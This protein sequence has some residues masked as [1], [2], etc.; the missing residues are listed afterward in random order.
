MVM[1]KKVARIGGLAAL[2]GCLASS[3]LAQ[4][5]T[6]T[7]SGTIADQGGG[8][9]PGVVVTATNEAT[10]VARE[11]VTDGEG[12]FIL[13]AS[14]PGIYTLSA[15]LPGFQTV[16]T[17]GIV[18]QVGQDLTFDLTLGVAAVAETVTVTGESP[19][20]NT[21]QSRIGYVVTEREIDTIPSQGR[22]QFGLVQLVPGV[23]PDL[24]ALGEGDFEGD[25][26]YANGQ[27]NDRNQWNV[28][29][30]SNQQS[31]GGGG[32]PQARISLDATA[33]FQ[34]LTHQYTAESGGASGVII[35]AITKSGTNQFAG[36]GFYFLH[37]REALAEE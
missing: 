22:T 11:G 21:T 13:S 15:G 34:V 23:T 7:V 8:V 1:L 6:A 25:A 31:N 14:P 18:V 10:Q 4:Q 9:L 17:E 27:S 28:D 24:G 20:V 30:V 16:V 12:V 32:G 3:A 29:G 37:K 26:F 35:N 5:S 19:L 36:R 2:V 33:E